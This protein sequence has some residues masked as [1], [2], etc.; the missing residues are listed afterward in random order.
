MPGGDR[1]FWDVAGVAGIEA[2]SGAIFLRGSGRNPGL[3]GGNAL[4][5]A[6]VMV[7]VAA[8]RLRVARGIGINV[9]KFFR[10]TTYDPGFDA[11]RLLTFELDGDGGGPRKARGTRGRGP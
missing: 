4:R 10:I 2:G 7:E 11:T 5:S 6:V 3:L 8:Y 9:A 1:N